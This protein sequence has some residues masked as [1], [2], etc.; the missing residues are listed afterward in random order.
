VVSSKS[1]K[2]ET[3]SDLER[4]SLDE[5]IAALVA[6]EPDK[7]VEWLTLLPTSKRPP[8]LTAAAHAW[9]ARLAAAEGDWALA[10]HQM[11]I[12][13]GVD[14]GGYSQRRLALLRRRQPVIDDK[15]WSTHGGGDRQGRTP[16]S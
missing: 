5:A 14:P 15:I 6:G 8:E 3:R 11:T 10:A 16:T 2:R 7:A 12:A 9:L 4:L 1:G 13:A